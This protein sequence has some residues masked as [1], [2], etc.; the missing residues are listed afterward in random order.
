MKFVFLGLLAVVATI[1][2][3]D[4]WR[5]DSRKRKRTK[6]F[7]LILILLYYLFSTDQRSW[8][9][10]AAL[11]TSWL[12]DVLL[13]G[14]GEKWFISGG[15]SFMIS[16]FFF[17]AVYATNVFSHSL[18]G[19]IWWIVIPAAIIY[20]TIAFLIVRSLKETAPKMMLV[21]LYIYLICNSAMNI[22][23]LIQLMTFRS[24]GAVIA[25]IGAIL[26][27]A[28]DCTLYLVRYHKNKDLIFKKHFTI[29][30]T[31]ILG[32]L[33]ITQGILMIG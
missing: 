16:H 13:M 6:P 1:H 18:D 23:S 26:F 3:I 15:I 28:S 19:I 25:Y 31:Y 29:M 11:A 7:L 2:L 21:P 14:K 30:L 20:L 12:G 22:F 27:F 5:D 4:S 8:I 10:I 24:P 33:L 9:L 32:E 17:I